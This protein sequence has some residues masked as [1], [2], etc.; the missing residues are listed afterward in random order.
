MFYYRF[1]LFLVL[2]IV[3]LNSKAYEVKIIAKVND[4]IITNID[5]DNRLRMTLDLSNLPNEKEVKEKLTPRVLDSLID[6]SLKIQEANRLGIYVT[7]QEVMTQINRLEKRLNLKK[8]TLLDNYK[9]KNIPEITILNQIRSQLLWEKMLYGIVIRNITISEKTI[10]ETYNLLLQKSGET[11]YNISEIFVSLNNLEAEQRINSIYNRA[12]NQNFLL[13]AEQ[14]SDG[15]VFLGDMRNNWIR[16]SLLNEE[17]QKVVSQLN[18][19]NISVPIKSSDGYHLILLNN[20]RKTKKIEEDQTIYDLSQ[21]LFKINNSEDLKSEAYYKEFLSYLSSIVNGCG[22]LKK[23]IEEIPEGIG[24]ELGRIDAKSIEDSFLKVLKNLPV[25]RLSDAVVT[26]DGVHGLML[27][28]PVIKNS[29]S[30]LK[31]NIEI[32]LKNKKIESAA[33]SLLSRIKRKALIELYK[34]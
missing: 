12:N 4:E 7:N 34:I 32:N 26:N 22:D 27:C 16:E 5:L 20:K 2:F 28:T 14:F 13:L 29:Y 8:N 15:V 1:L 25:G 19:G 31:K 11:E 21:I 33:Q 17:I 23:L 24:G 10:L 6:E 18:V 3:C 30:E 9:K